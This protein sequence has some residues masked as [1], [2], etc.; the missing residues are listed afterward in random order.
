MIMNALRFR[1]AVTLAGCASSPDLSRDPSSRLI[2]VISEAAFLFSALAQ[3]FGPEAINSRLTLIE[4]ISFTTTPEDMLESLT[5]IIGDRAVGA[6][7]LA[8]RR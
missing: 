6:C 3:F 7:S 8:T 1:G 4:T 2:Y 5:R